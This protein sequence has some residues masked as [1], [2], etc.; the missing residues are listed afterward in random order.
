MLQG[1]HSAI[2]STYIKVPFVIKIVFLSIFEGLPK[3][4]F[5]VIVCLS[6]FSLERSVVFLSLLFCLVST[7]LILPSPNLVWSRI[8]SVFKCLSVLLICF[9]LSVCMSESFQDYS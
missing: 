8:Y 3:T 7:F 2:L 9:F 1:Q 6:F 4:G 5:T